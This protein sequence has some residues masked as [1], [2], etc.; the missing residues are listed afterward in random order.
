MSTITGQEPVA[1]AAA[2]TAFVTAVLAL[3]VFLNVIPEEAS[4]LILAVIAAGIPLVARVVRRKV[5]PVQ[6]P[7]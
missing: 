6:N 3:L 4:P 1:T 2:I 5:T 7:V